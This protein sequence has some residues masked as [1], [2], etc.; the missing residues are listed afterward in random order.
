MIKVIPEY[1][2]RVPVWVEGMFAGRCVYDRN[3]FATV[4]SRPQRFV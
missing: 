3:R 4:R 2:A 1:V